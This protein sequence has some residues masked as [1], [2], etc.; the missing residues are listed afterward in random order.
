MPPGDKGH[1]MKFAVIGAGLA[2]L[3]CAEGLR[4]GG[5]EVALF[6]KGR[7]AGGRMASRR[8][9]TTHGEAGFD[10][11]AQYMTAHDP[12]FAARLADW[13]SGGLAA[14]WPAAGEA[15]WVG[16]PSMKAPLRRMAAEF[17]VRW[18]ARIE[19]LEAD[20]DGWRLHGEGADAAR[21]DGVVVALPAEQAGALL[22]P[23]AADMAQRAIATPSTPC[24]T[25]MAAFAERLPIAEDVLRDRGEI[26]WA[27]RN[28]AK[29][30]RT[31]LE[32]WVVQA[33][34]DWSL[35]HLEDAPAGVLAAM[36]GM[37]AGEAGAPLAGKL[38]V[39]VHRWRYARSGGSGEGMLW[40][41]ARRLGAC[42]D[43][44]LGPRVES[45]FL[46]GRRLAAAI[47]A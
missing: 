31:A 5:H 47:Q 32:A 34:P 27:A 26:G 16:V 45:A 35:A 22:A 17:G 7:G 14:R 8:V 20:G 19:A 36:Q 25:M 43:W 12:A 18:M 1:A 2:G 15:A 23:V 29:P 41:P 28:S 4:S 30:G 40:D 21:Y 38:F 46:S 3:T 6:D 37:L 39:S 33:T 11:G 44:L 9:Q 42:G 13:A 10:H 24:W